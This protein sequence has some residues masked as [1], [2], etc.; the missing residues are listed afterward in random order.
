MLD[1]LFNKVYKQSFTDVLQNSCSWIFR[2]FLRKVS[3]SES[4]L[5]KM[6]ALRTA[7]FWQE[8]T[9]QVFSCKICKF[10]RTP[11]LQ[12][13]FRGSFW[14]F[15]ASSLQFYLKRDLRITASCV[16]LWILRSFLE[17]LFYIT[18]AK[19]LVSCTRCKSSTSR[20]SKKLFTGVFQAFYKT[21][22]GS[23]SK[24]FMYLK[25]L[26]IIFEEINS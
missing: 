11:F 13:I 5:I 1:S 26:K 2:K 17:Y 8:T 4:F 24:A 23:N 3:V 14:Q 15:Q 16:Y 19:L 7:F 12:N 9:I 25:P 6:Q 20:Y 22:K 21:M 18:S 10:L